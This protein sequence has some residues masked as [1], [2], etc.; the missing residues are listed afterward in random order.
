[1]C[2]FSVTLNYNVIKGEHLKT[3]PSAQISKRKENHLSRRH[4]IDI[5]CFYAVSLLIWKKCHLFYGCLHALIRRVFARQFIQKRTCISQVDIHHGRATTDGFA[6]NGS[7][8]LKSQPISHCLLSW[9]LA[10]LSFMCK[11]C[12]S[13][14]SIMHRGIKSLYHNNISLYD[15]KNI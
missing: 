4:V 3:R 5:Q 11:V 6:L 14:F 10:G 8:P 9:G 2:L 13:I 1:M 15:K 12:F 7:L